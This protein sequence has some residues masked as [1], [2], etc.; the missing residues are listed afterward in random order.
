MAVD[1]VFSNLGRM[2]EMVGKDKGTAEPIP[3]DSVNKI[4][5]IETA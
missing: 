5:E 3:V 2:I 1:N 4:K